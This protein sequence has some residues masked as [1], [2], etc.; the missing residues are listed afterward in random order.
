MSKGQMLFSHLKHKESGSERQYVTFSKFI[1]AGEQKYP[2]Y[3]LKKI[4]INFHYNKK[5]KQHKKR[6]K[7]REREEGK[8]EGRKNTDWVKSISLPFLKYK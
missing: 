5:Q 2:F 6:K 1:I 8:K 7:E 4:H 3:K